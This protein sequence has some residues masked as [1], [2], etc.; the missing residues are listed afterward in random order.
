[1]K[2]PHIKQII[3]QHSY[4]N[5]MSLECTR[6]L[7]KLQVRFDLSQWREELD[8][9]VQILIEYLRMAQTNRIAT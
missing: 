2:V 6:Q 8:G 7:L 1:M 5:R 9:F 3:N 4:L